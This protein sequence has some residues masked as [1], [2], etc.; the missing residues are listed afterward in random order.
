MI[1]NI[2]IDSKKGKYQSK[3]SFETGGILVNCQTKCLRIM[4]IRE[5]EMLRKRMKLYSFI[6]NIGHQSGEMVARNVFSIYPNA[7]IY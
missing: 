4:V 7:N 5:L 2:E 6:L 3:F 1:H